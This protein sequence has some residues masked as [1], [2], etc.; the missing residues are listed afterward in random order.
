MNN[1]NLVGNAGTSELCTHWH[2]PG[3]PKAHSSAELDAATSPLPCHPWGSPGCLQKARKSP[4]CYQARAPKVTL[5]QCSPGIPIPSKP[6]SIST[7]QSQRGQLQ[8]ASCSP[9]SSNITQLPCFMAFGSGG[10]MPA[11]FFGQLLLRG[12]RLRGP[13]IFVAQLMRAAR[14]CSPGLTSPTR[15][16]VFQSAINSLYIAIKCDKWAAKSYF[17]REEA[18]SGSAAVL[19]QHDPLHTWLSPLTR[20]GCCPTLKY[21][22]AQLS[23]MFPSLVL[24]PVPSTSFLDFSGCC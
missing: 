4:W 22:R 18:P 2:S 15:C 6:W 5:P 19:A 21:E 9:I 7:L 3:S 11:F 20:H 8:R 23:G 13:R 16:L 12:E 10:K 24:S 14:T 1:T 17:G